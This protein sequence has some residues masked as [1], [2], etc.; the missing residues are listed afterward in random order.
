MCVLF[1]SLTVFFFV[2]VVVVIV[3]IFLLL[4]GFLHYVVEIVRCHLSCHLS[5]G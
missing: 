4:V 3:V 2:V 5:P 1:F